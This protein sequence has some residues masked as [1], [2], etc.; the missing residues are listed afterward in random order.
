MVCIEKDPASD[1][2]IYLDNAAT[3]YPKPGLVYDAMDAFARYGGGSGGRSGHSK[4]IEASG[5]L[6]G[7]RESL[8]LLLGASAPECVCFAPNATEA[9]N[10]AI[11]GLA[12]PG[13]RI[14]TTSMEHNSVWRPL[15]DLRDR[16]GCQV[17]IVRAG[18]DGVCDGR[19]RVDAITGDTALVVMTFASNVAGTLQPVEAVA[20]RCRERSI[21][22]VV[23]AAQVAGAY[24][25]NA[26]DLGIGALAF[27][28]HKSLL[29]PQGTGGLVVDPALV[30][31]IRPLK[32]GGTGSRSESDR[33]P[34]A[35]PD[36][37]ESGTS[38]GHG[39]AGL[40]AGVEYLLEEGVETV[41]AREMALWRRLRDGLRE[42]Q[43]VRVYGSDDA[44]RS[45]GTVSITV[46]GMEPT[47]VGFL[48]DVKHGILTRTGL[49]C[50]PLAH[51]T[52]GTMP[53]GTVRF[54][55]GFATTEAHVDAA[56]EALV[57]IR[58]K[59]S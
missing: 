35:L 59:R 23:D 16:L 41:R 52:L 24:P 44:A 47:D 1:S 13:C 22:L 5:I 46:D 56:L 14:V 26:V 29:G 12:E 32:R 17:V 54:S 57:H 36:K 4:S 9:L 53:H 2:W 31:R 15:A 34:D 30:P 45:V 48:L 20:A 25:L 43:H 21:P 6:D 37:F 40:L 19:R 27:T 39:I 51:Q 49:H 42:I 38:N 8:A 33:Q 55:L 28:G 50:A 7:A 10:L 58:D 11:Y 18:T 3:S